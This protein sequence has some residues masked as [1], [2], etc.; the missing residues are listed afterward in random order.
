M[1]ATA[2][3]SSRNQIRN[4]GRPGQAR[5]QY[6]AEHAARAECGVEVA[7]AGLAAMQQ[8]DRENEIQHV[9]R[10]RDD[11]VCERHRPARR[12]GTLD[13]P[14]EIPGS[15]VG[16]KR[17]VS[18]A[19]RMFSITCSNGVGLTAMVPLN[20]Y[21]SKRISARMTPIKTPTVATMT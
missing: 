5:G 10:A 16:R 2:P 15:E 3:R 4:R 17:D 20:G 19:E 14:W 12:R 9:K 8:R 18:L 6:D 7:D 13:A 11:E 1:A 21:S